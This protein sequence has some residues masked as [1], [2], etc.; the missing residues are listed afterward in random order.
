MFAGGFPPL[1]LTFTP[2]FPPALPVPVPPPLPGPPPAPPLAPG[3]PFGAP[4]G[5]RGC[6]PS[7]EMETRAARF[8]CG[9]MTGAG[10]AGVAESAI[11]VAVFPFATL[12]CAP[13]S[14]AGPASPVCAR[15]ATRGAAPA[16]NSSFGRAG[17]LGNIAGAISESFWSSVG[18]SGAGAEVNLTL[19]SSRGR[20]LESVSGLICNRGRAG[21]VICWNCTMFGRLGR[22]FGGSGGAAELIN[23]WRGCVG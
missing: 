10:G 8:P 12:G 5:A 16:F 18:R 20:N 22:I 14:G 21:P 17:A 4:P 6:L 2:F 7:G 3:V 13:T 9:S 19:R 11:N 1:M 15:G 23:V